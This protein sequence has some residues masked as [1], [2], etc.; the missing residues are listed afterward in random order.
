MLFQSTW[1]T[2]LLAIDEY[3][4][5]KR[6]D[7]CLCCLVHNNSSSSNSSNSSER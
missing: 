5:E 4:V 7:A 2:A 3:R 6:R 1:F